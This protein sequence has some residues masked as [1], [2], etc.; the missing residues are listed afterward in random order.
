MTQKIAGGPLRLWINLRDGMPPPGAYGCGGDISAGTGATPSCLSI[1]SRE[2]GEKVCEYANAHI[3]PIELAPLAVALCRAFRDTDD[4]GAAFAWEMQ[5]PGKK[6][7]DRVV[8]T[9]GYRNIYYHVREDKLTKKQSD[10][11]GFYPSP[12]AKDDLLK[13][14]KHALTHRNFINRSILALEE[15]LDFSYQST[16]HIEHGGAMNT[17]DPTG[18]RVNHGDRCISDALAWMMVKG[19]VK[20]LRRPPER[21]PG[22]S[23]LAGR[24]KMAENDRELQEVWD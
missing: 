19:S 16:G 21:L 23:S 9:L 20:S 7:G 8:N 11:Y 17:N 2:T 1:V 10:V 3:E 15:C 14:Y 13:E 18:A 22:P 5:G 12:D 6:F 24:R 4:Q